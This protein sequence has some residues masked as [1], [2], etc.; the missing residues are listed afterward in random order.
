MD[1]CIQCTELASSSEVSSSAGFRNSSSTFSTARSTPWLRSEHFRA[2]STSGGFRASILHH[3]SRSRRFGVSIPEHFSTSGGFGASI[4]E[5]LRRLEAS[6]RAFSSIVNVRRLRSED[7]R[8]FS[9]R[10]APPLLPSCNLPKPHCTT[11]V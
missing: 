9:R 4:F 11:F 7:F 10:A 2:S 8:D 5:H 1:P 6:E 3:F